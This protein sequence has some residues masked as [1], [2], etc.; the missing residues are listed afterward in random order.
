MYPNPSFTSLSKGFRF[1]SQISVLLIFD[2]IQYSYKEDNKADKGLFIY[3]FNK[4][5]FFEKNMGIVKIF[6]NNKTF[7]K[8]NFQIYTIITFDWCIV[9]TIILY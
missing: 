1:F 3:V 5:L 7:D 8:S 6:K 4:S 9:P 2:F